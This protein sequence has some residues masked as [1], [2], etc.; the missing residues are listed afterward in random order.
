MEGRKKILLCV[1]GCLALIFG[2][3]IFFAL[4]LPYLIN[5]EPV[6]EKILTFL[7]RRMEGKVQFQKIDLFYFP[8]PRVEVHR[9]NLAIHEKVA[10]TLKSVRVYPELLPLLKG[11]LRITEV[12]I[13]SPDFTIQFPA[14]RE[15]GK[16]KPG[17][18]VLERFKEIT[19]LASGIVPGL[20]L[21]V[22]GG[23]LNCAQGS[24]TVFSFF[25]INASMTGASEDTKI[26]LACR[27]N[28]WEKM[29]VEA[30]INPVSLKG[31]G[32]IEVKSFHPH[33]LPASIFS[34]FPLNVKDSQLNLKMSI[35]AK[36]QGVF[37]AAVEGSMGRLIIGNGNE[38]IAIK[39][40]RFQGVLRMGEEGIEISLDELSLEYPRLKLLGKIKIDPKAPLFVVEAQGREVDVTSTRE[41]AK[42][43]AGKLPIVKRVFDI[44]K[45]GKVPLITFHSR[46]RT[47]S[48]L[49]KTENFSMKGSI[50]DGKISIPGREP[51]GDKDDFT[52][53][54]TTGDVVISRGVAEGRNL[55]ARWQNQRLEQGI[56]RLGLIGEDAPLHFEVEIDTALSLLPPLLG[57]MVEDQTFLKEMARFHEIEGRA[58]GRLILGGR[59]KAISVKV[60][61]RDMNVFARYDR[62]PYPITIDGGEGG[63]DGERV[64]FRNVSGK[65]GNTSF[66]QLTAQLGLEQEPTLAIPSGRFSVALGEVYPWLASFQGVR[67]DLKDV[68]AI[69]GTLGLTVKDLYGPLLKPRQW[70]FETTGEVRRLSAKTSLFPEP[71]EVTAGAFGA[72]A[73]KVSFIGVRINTLGASFNISGHL[74]GYLKGPIQLDLLSQVDLA[75]LP[76]ILIPLLKNEAFGKELSLVENLEGNA[77]GRL[78]LDDSGGNGKVRVEISN[79]SASAKYRRIPYILRI[80]SAEVS[81]RQN[82]I[83][84]KNLTGVVGKSSFL[85]LEAQLDLAKEPY[86]EIRSGKLVISVDEIYAWLSPRSLCRTP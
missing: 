8:R 73:E 68:D 3:F 56:L 32:R 36:G 20:R 6:K 76:P 77:T 29:S 78:V 69:E 15:E 16:G 45:E 40:N 43:L 52:L 37:Q 67:E 11:K 21:V 5:L 84:V 38:E 44:V 35:E 61:I 86:L 46:G 34:G 28:L 27:S 81:Y 22:G 7:S 63:F 57:R 1:T 18:T 70:R 23:K 39:G 62:I 25:D 83:G 14:A 19:A 13:E 51:G 66:S 4:C 49:G 48:A 47:L 79:L 17:A 58:T 30:K 10:G 60:G 54:E 31:H 72:D 71:I 75:K 2:L 64:E 59:L 26:E 42:L 9:V 80:R 24:Q 55:R 50:L 53:E 65:V 82:K 12:Q 33:L 41:V 85:D 74:D